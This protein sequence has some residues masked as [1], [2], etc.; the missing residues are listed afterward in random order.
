MKIIWENIINIIELMIEVNQSAIANQLGMD[1]SV[2]SRLK[3]GKQL[4]LKKTSHEIFQAI[5]DPQAENSFAYGMSSQDLLENLKAVVKELDLVAL[6]K[7]LRDDYYREFVQELLRSVKKNEPDN[8][9]STNDFSSD[10]AKT[11]E[12]GQEADAT[13][14]CIQDDILVETGENAIQEC[15]HHENEYA[16]LTI[17]KSCKVC[18]CCDNWKGNVCNAYKSSGG[19]EGKCIMYNKNTLSVDGRS[20]ERFCPNYGRITQ[21]N[22][23]QPMLEFK[24]RLK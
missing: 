17:P 20:C 2:I 10:E 13:Q 23:L 19:V 3:S 21:Y 16:Q 15:M 1:R 8:S 11:E 14:D 9:S 18:L 22:F 7:D 5:F 4:S 6:T 12:N 24:K